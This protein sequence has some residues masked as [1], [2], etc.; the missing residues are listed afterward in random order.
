M[1]R[2]SDPLN[3]LLSSSS[4]E[5]SNVKVTR[6]L[7]GYIYAS[8]TDD[9]IH[10]SGVDKISRRASGIASIASNKGYGH[11]CGHFIVHGNSSSN[12]RKMDV[13]VKLASNFVQAVHATVLEVRV[14]GIHRGHQAYEYMRRSARRRLKAVLV[15]RHWTLPLSSNAH[16]RADPTFVPNATLQSVL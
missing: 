11:D 10:R 16:R 15:F 8:V 5:L 9:Y 13:F 12:G 4:V 7:S 2:I 1:Y 6:P 14:H 3:A